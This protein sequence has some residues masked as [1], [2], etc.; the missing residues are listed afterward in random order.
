MSAS[1]IIVNHEPEA[2][3]A[4]SQHPVR[5]ISPAKR[6][7]KGCVLRKKTAKNAL[8]YNLTDLNYINSLLMN[9]VC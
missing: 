1:A 6:S 2:I 3:Y 7:N 4:L 9:I 5:G 8:I